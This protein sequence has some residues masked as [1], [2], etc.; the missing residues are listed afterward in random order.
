MAPA[1][2]YILCVILI[3]LLN[4]ARVS[5]QT[6]YYTNVRQGKMGF[7]SGF[8]SENRPDEL[9]NVEV[10]FTA[11]TISNVDTK[12]GY[13]TIS[14]WFT[15]TWTDALFQ[16][17]LGNIDYIFYKKSSLWTPRLVVF[18]AINGFS[19]LGDDND[20]IRIGKD[21][22]I[23]WEPG[24]QFR[25]KCDV[26]QPSLIC[27]LKLSSWMYANTEVELVNHASAID[28]SLVSLD[29]KYSLKTS[30]L[31]TVVATSSRATYPTTHLIYS[32]TI[33]QTSDS[34]TVTWVV[35]V[36]YVLLSCAHLLVFTLSVD[37]TD[38][39]AFSANMLMA[40]A[41][42]LVVFCA[43]LEVGRDG[44]NRSVSHL[45]IHMF[46]MF[47]LT[48]LETIFNA[49]VVG[50][51]ENHK[52]NQPLG[53]QGCMRRFL[54]RL[55]CFRHSLVRSNIV[56]IIDDNGAH[57]NRKLRTKISQPSKQRWNASESDW[58]SSRNFDRIKSASTT[59]G[60]TDSQTE[61]QDL[62]SSP[63][64]VLDDDSATEFKAGKSAIFTWA[65][66]ATMWGRVFFMT[67][68][69]IRA[70]TVI[71]CFSVILGSCGLTFC[72]S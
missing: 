52:N 25:V 29:E 14:G 24:G 68:F 22:V 36:T 31:E 47:A 8:D 63:S 27:K 71:V 43:I 2:G 56:G 11:T 6:A 45:E 50:I 3:F 7:S 23:R 65:D 19:I 62:E 35:V 51:H 60:R 58:G 41:L 20:M 61:S 34:Q 59:T 67:F 10:S 18:N 57:K 9:M 38:K 46:A 37:T 26:R 12:S 53:K 21:G 48:V 66:I 40:L 44:L 13:A 32:F 69:L 5:S 39:I 64:N 4:T 1:A 70:F 15:L 17:S 30:G 28:T 33:D 72:V 55:S 49:V 16:W 54:A 42:Y